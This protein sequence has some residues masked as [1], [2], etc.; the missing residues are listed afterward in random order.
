[1]GKGEGLRKRAAPAWARERL[2]RLVVRDPA[3][4]LAEQEAELALVEAHEPGRSER[5]EQGV[6]LASVWVVGGV[7]D[8]LRRDLPVEVEQVDCAPNGG[9]EVDAGDSAESSG[10]AG[11]VGD[12]GVRD[13]Q[14][15]AVGA[16]NELL[17][18]L[19]DRG[20]AAPSVNEDGHSVVD[21]EHED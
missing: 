12:P 4:A 10:Q 14:P 7:E 3:R 9:V 1:P 6:R 16:L 2:G 18:V 15:Y 5:R 11:H 17:E 21:R 19:G 20:Q 13:D 8:L